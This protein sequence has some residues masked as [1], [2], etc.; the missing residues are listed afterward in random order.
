MNNPKP[1][2]SIITVVLNQVDTIENTIKSVIRQEY[3][4]FEYIIIDGGSTDGTLGIIEKYKD[5]LSYFVS[6]SD[7]GIYHAMNKGVL[8]S[9]GEVVYF[10]GADDILLK[11]DCIPF[12]M[13]KYKDLNLDM[14]YGN[15]L[16]KVKKTRTNRLGRRYFLLDIKAGRRP[17]HQAIFMSKNKILEA[18]MFNY[19][20]YKIAADF[21]LICYFFI[22]KVRMSYQ[23]IDVAEFG[24]CG[25][26]SRFRDE[27]NRES[28]KVIR[29]YFGYFREKAFIIKKN[30][31]AFLRL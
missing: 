12:M 18:G 19:L 14:I 11:K 23:N 31:R 27:V 3:D 2:L 13:A 21:N 17:P 1:F 20:N 7:K 5:K 15:V 8:V 24:S 22:N 10:L 26:S 16:Y 9:C 4:G 28:A 30:I 6:E 25:V 29:I